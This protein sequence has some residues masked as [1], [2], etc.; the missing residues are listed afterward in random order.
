MGAQGL[1]L[2]PQAASLK[3]SAAAK[4]VIELFESERGLI[5]VLVSC[6]G[7]ACRMSPNELDASALL[8]AM[9]AKYHR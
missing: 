2:S 1:N 9:Q 7:A 8:G 3:D 5:R 6:A 4:A